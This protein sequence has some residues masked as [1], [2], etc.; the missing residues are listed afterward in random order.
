LWRGRHKA[1]RRA[2]APGF[3]R[4]ALADMRKRLHNALSKLELRDQD[5]ARLESRDRFLESELVWLEREAT[6]AA[7]DRI[8]ARQ[9]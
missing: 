1:E 5:V 2:T 9:R 6:N 4:E 8:I 3:D 7:K